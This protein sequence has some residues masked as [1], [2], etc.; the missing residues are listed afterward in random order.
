MPIAGQV[1]IIGSA[2]TP[3]G[4]LHDRGYLELL[5]EAALG[6][7]ADAGVEQER[8]EAAWLGTA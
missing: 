1:A 8:V 2:A 4:V 7:I 6:A 5:G 3:F